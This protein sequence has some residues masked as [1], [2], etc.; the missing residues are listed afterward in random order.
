MIQYNLVL[1][2]QFEN[3]GDG[4]FLKKYSPYQIEFLHGLVILH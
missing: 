3:D 1:G 4:E 2:G